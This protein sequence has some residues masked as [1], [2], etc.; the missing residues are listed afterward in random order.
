MSEAHGRLLNSR[1]CFKRLILLTIGAISWKRRTASLRRRSVLRPAESVAEIT[2]ELMTLRS[3]PRRRPLDGRLRLS[4]EPVELWK[5]LELVK[6]WKATAMG[7][8]HLAA[9][10]FTTVEFSK[11]EVSLPFV[12]WS[13]STR[14]AKFV[15]RVI[16]ECTPSYCR[17]LCKFNTLSVMFTTRLFKAGI[18]IID[19]PGKP[20]SLSMHVSWATTAKRSPENVSGLVVFCKA[21]LSRS[22]FSN[23]SILSKSLVEQKEEKRKK[24]DH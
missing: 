21:E 12:C 7:C 14:A 6:T 13:V 16:A 22:F 20:V 15:G 2:T 23:S 11:E 18:D 1:C 17:K 3:C 4:E 19:L 5:S 9:A 10:P 8:W 24:N